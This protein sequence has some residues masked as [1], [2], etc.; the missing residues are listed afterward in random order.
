MRSLGVPE[1]PAA[2]V[3]A[4]R[5]TTVW[6]R[7][8]SLM[9]MP[10]DVFAHAAPSPWL[11]GPF[12]IDCGASWSLRVS[13]RAVCALCTHFPSMR[14]WSHH[15]FTYATECRSHCAARGNDGLRAYLCAWHT[16]L[17]TM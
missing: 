12:P 5:A 13:G 16:R 14:R 1:S 3:A 17:Q 6:Q 15:G 4:L 2:R 9:S 10:V 11:H 8:D 7:E